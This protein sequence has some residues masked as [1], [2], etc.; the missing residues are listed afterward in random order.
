MKKVL[1]SKK[2]SIVASIFFYLQ[3]SATT[4]TISVWDG[5]FKFLPQN[6]TIQLGDTLQWLPL[7]A[8]TMVHTITS[9]NI[10]SGAAPFNYIWQA[11]SDTFF[12]YVPQVAGIYDYECTPHIAWGMIGTITVN[13]GS[14]GI[15]PL[16]NN[17]NDFKFFPNPFCDKLYIESKHDMLGKN[18]SLIN[19]LGQVVSQGVILSALTEVNLVD[20]PQ[21][22]YIFFLDSRKKS[23]HKI[24]T[25]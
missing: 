17:E 20:L 12:Q 5:Y 3:L 14:V 15:N 8:P 7:D 2:L 4:H 24:N 10:P 21:G 25:H 16:K 22:F 18:Y 13:A 9:T 1:F 19:G 23:I 11:P 6:L